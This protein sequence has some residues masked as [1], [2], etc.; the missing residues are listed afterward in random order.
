VS[1]E[2]GGLRR[3]LQVLRARWLLAFLVAGPMFIGIALTVS[4]L[5][6]QY[7]GSAVLAFAPRPEAG[8]G[9]DTFAEV[10]GKYPRIAVAA[11]TT[12]AAAQRSGVSSSVL[13][14][15]VQAKFETTT[16]NLV[17]TV[18]LSSPVQASRA[19]NAVADLLVARATTDSLV[20]AE[21]ASQSTPPTTPSQPKTRLFWGMGLLVALIAGMTVALAAQAWQP[22][23][24]DEEDVTRV[25]GVRPAVRLGIEAGIH[26]HGYLAPLVARVRQVAQ[27][28]RSPV[29]V[30]VGSVS[31]AEARVVAQA[32]VSELT[33]TGIVV[34]YD[35]GVS[36]AAAGEVGGVRLSVFGPL[37]AQV[38]QPL[39]LQPAGAVLAVPQG[40]P[41]NAAAATVDLLR[42]WNAEL[43]GAVV[44][45]GRAG[46]HG[47]RRRRFKRSPAKL[48][49]G[50]HDGVSG[51][52]ASDG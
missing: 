34:F 40:S 46:A 22:K 29:F 51:C 48:G 1:D 43:L 2:S 17:I 45:H 21:V 38:P 30:I 28:S 8:L 18:Q 11:A 27:H 42:Q 23:V 32:L 3:V 7:D 47:A 35:S 14:N 10:I 19:A 52:W 39:P 24:L 49:A 13:A 12:H 4:Q 31:L 36:S 44:V 9:A 41:A 16:A 50:N 37:H 15:K 6:K 25:T 20:T 5:P 26:H 33:R